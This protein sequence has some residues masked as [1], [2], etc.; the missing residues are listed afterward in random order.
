M[1]DRVRAR[2]G[3]GLPCNSDMGVLGSTEAEGRQMEG[4]HC[5]GSVQLTTSSQ[6]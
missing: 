2:S 5:W 1:G 3:G 6:V 4:K